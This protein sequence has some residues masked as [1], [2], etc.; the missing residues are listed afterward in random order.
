M[1]RRVI[2]PNRYL[3][4]VL[5]A[6]QIAITIIFFYWPASQALIQSV[7]L[8]DPFGLRTRF[9]FLENFR[10]VLSDPLYLEAVQVTVVFSLLVAV[11]AMAL[12]LLFA[13]MADRKI[14]AARTYKTMLLWPYAL[15]PAVAAVLWVFIFH[16]SFGLAGRALNDWGIPWDYKL[17]GAEA[18][19]LVV[20]ASAWRQVAYNFL[21]YLAGLQ[22]IPPAVTEAAM[23]DG[24]GAWKLFRT[25]LFPL[26]SPTTFFLLTVNLVYAFFD[27]F[28]VIHALTGGGPGRATTT[29]MYKVYLDGVFNLNLGQSAAQS[30][31]LM[32]IVSGIVWLQFR[33]VES[34]VHYT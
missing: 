18:F 6:P 5:L 29:L 21:F 30:V 34:R 16:P 4:Y 28:G 2:F 15:A 8:Q 26:L 9:V 19:L 11:L 17:N 1:R 25:V 24:A 33:F 20:L 12:G 13:V 23:I 22:S 14:R 32:L 27:T 3:P 10:T 31:I 7:L